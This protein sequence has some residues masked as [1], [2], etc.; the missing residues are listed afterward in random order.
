MASF[1]DTE[2]FLPNRLVWFHWLAMEENIG[3]M[4]TQTILRSAGLPAPSAS[5]PWNDLEKSIDFSRYAALCSSIADAYGE[6]AARDLLFR[7]ARKAFPRLL[8]GTAAIA[9]VEGPRFFMQPDHFRITEGL[10]SVS[11]LLRALSD[12]RCS[13]T[14]TGDG[15][16]FSILLC[17]E[18]A[19]RSGEDC[20]C[21]SM[22][23]MIRGALDWF[24][25][26]PAVP[27]REVRCKASG[28]EE[29]EFSVQ[30]G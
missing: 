5:F 24:G 4:G 12:M 13:S 16:R 3:R 27:V 10:A 19:G 23:G 18:C 1:P 15:W 14:R 2:K 20:I 11:K 7:S 9:G 21:Q 28:S 29:C 6:Q 8:Q 25:M 17:P 22:A 30:E 26:D